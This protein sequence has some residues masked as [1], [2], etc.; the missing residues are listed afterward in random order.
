MGKT[1]AARLGRDPPE[2]TGNP[3][4]LVVL[5]IHERVPPLRAEA[6]SEFVDKLM[7]QG[8]KNKQPAS[9]A[10]SSHAPPSKRFR[11]EPVGEKEVG[12][13]RYGRKAMPTASGPAL[14]LGPR[15][16][17]S[18]GSA[19]TSTPPPRSSPAPSG[20]GNTSASLSGGTTNSGRAA[21]S[22]SDHRTEEDLSFLPEHQDTGASNTGAG[23][24][25]AAGRAEPSAPPV[26]EKTT[27]A[28]ESSAPEGSNTGDAPSAPPSPRT[29]LMPPPEAPRAQPSKAAPSA[30]PAKTS[31][32]SSTAP[33]PKPS[34]LIKGKATASSAPSGGQQP[35]VLHVSKAAK[36]ASM[37]ATGLLGRITEFQRQGR[38]LGHL[39][40]YAQKWNAADITPATRGMGK[41]R[42]PAP[43]PVGDRC[44]EEHFMRLR[45]AVKELD[46]AWYDSTNNLTVTADTRK[47][48]FEEL[49][50][51]HRE[52]AEAHDKCQVIPEASIDALKEQLAE[53]QREKDQL[54]RQHQEELNALKTS[55]QELKSQLIQL[56]LDHAKAL[57][58]AE[59][60]AAAKLDEALE[61][62]CNATV[63]LRAELEEMAK[64]RKGAEEKAARLEEE[65][66][67]CDQLILQTD[68]LALRLFPDS[69]RY[70]VKKVDAQRKDKGQADLTVPWTPKDHLVAL[71][72]RVSHMR[73]IDRNLSDIPDVATQL[74]R[75]LWPGEEVPDT[76]TLISDR[77]KGAGKRIREWQCSAAR[78]GADSALRVACSWYPE[79]NLDALTGVREGAETDLDPILT[80]KRQDRAYRIAEYADM[81]TFIP[82][83][84]GVTDYLDEEEGEAEEEVLDDAD[85][86]AAPP[87]APAA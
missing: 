44:S 79:L 81:R 42:L 49:L 27:S 80:A 68:T 23:E 17:G 47:A 63:V 67:E 58:A 5:E 14:K 59:V 87:E 70:A 69:Q 25:E 83:P 57:K 16:S 51:E 62:A 56:G 60:T 65:H 9:T 73:C 61:D 28:P 24:E 20:A 15:P 64:A 30:P 4:D 31:G 54:N 75:T 40:P 1:P 72:A 66:K 53:A 34:K 46:S 19:R 38:D 3:E 10:G 21:P 2:P 13:R 52:L 39:L 29:I 85:A 35:L 6:G 86:G 22:L 45:A 77:L 48:L 50:W 26:L 37:K 36:G 32:A 78:A 8:Q 41:D 71:N 43:D 11:T 7:A 12:V 33:P 84:P 74:Y 55:Y 18:E 82:P 76:F